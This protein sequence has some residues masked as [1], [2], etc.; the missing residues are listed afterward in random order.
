MHATLGKLQITN[1]AH[2]QQSAWNRINIR[3]TGSE[4]LRIAIASFEG[5]K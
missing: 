2:K 3:F 1:C 4:P 5:E